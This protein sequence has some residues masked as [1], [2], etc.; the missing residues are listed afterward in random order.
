MFIVALSVIAKRWKQM[1]IDE[2]VH[3]QI[4]V[5]TYNGV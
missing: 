4:V 2:Y 1:P 3:K 5:Y